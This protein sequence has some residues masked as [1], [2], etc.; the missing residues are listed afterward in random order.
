MRHLRSTLVAIVL[1]ACGVPAAETS[2]ALRAPGADSSP[3]IEARLVHD[4]SAPRLV[5]AEYRGETLY[6]DPQP[7]FS[8]PDFLAVHA[9]VRPGQV[10]IDLRC[11]P[12]GDE[13]TRSVTAAAIGRRMAILW[14]S[15]VRGAPTVRSAVGCTG[16]QIGFDAPAHEADQVAAT[17]RARWPAQAGPTTE[18]PDL[19]RFFE[20]YGAR[21]TFVVLEDRGGGRIMHNAERAAE[22]FLPA[23]TFKIM[24]SLVALETGV[25]GLDDTIAWDG[26][27]RGVGSWNQDQRMRDAFQWSTVWFYQELA[28]R[29]GEGRMRGFLLREDYGNADTGGGIDE[30]W[31]SGDLRISAQEQV[32]FL[33]RLRRRQL[34]FPAEVVGVVEELMVLE[35]CPDYTLRGKTGWARPGG[36]HLGWLVGWAEHAGDVHYYALN[37][38]SA[39]DDFPMIEARQSITR[40]ILAE[41]GILPPAEDR[42]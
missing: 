42:C 2:H 26:V 23:S 24:N 18:R 17:V 22:G 20:P 34:Q 7:V 3:L 12:E 15:E 37:L 39:A 30:F 11:R 6:L 35:R 25:V 9:S 16:T 5:A 29:V 28:R 36:V 14:D 8:D 27:D 41:L 4:S 19:G 13:R 10:V 38:E 31:L 1:A 33:K 32:D 21:G 40:G